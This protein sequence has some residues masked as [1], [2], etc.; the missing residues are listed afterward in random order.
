MV[1]PNP[2]TVQMVENLLEALAEL[3]KVTRSTE[4]N[5]RRA[6]KLAKSGA[7]VTTALVACNPS[8]TRQSMN[9]ALKSVEV[10]RHA[11]RL[12]IFKLGLEEGMSIGDLGRSFGFSRQLAARYAREA[13]ETA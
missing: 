11:M 8:E 12:R 3:R 1:T 13:K 6:L 4:A 10:A 9:D 7:D 2:D 5:V